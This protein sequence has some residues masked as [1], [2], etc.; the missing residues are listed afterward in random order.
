MSRFRRNGK[1]RMRNRTVLDTQVADPGFP[2][3]GGGN[4]LFGQNFPENCIKMK[5]LGPG[6]GGWRIPGA[7]P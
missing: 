7:L 2:R 1:G 6:V 3:G 4:L 5:E